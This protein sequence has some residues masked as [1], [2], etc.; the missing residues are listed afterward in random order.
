[1]PSS[2]L[3]RGYSRAVGY[4]TKLA[5]RLCY[6]LHDRTG[7]LDSTECNALVVAMH[8]EHIASTDR[9]AVCRK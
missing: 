8:L 5:A 2:E 3:V 7:R 6:D 9:S 1:M 4:G